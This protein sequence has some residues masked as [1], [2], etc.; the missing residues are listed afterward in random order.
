MQTLQDALLPLKIRASAI[1]V[2]LAKLLSIAV[3]TYTYIRH[4]RHQRPVNRLIYYTVNKLQLC[5]DACDSST[6]VV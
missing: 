4:A 6:W 2:F 3:I 5:Q 1:H